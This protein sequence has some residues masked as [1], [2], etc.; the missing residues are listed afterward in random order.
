MYS[1][2]SILS[3]VERIGFGQDR[4]INIDDSN[5]IGKSGRLFSFYHKLVT[6]KNLY[7]TVEEAN[8]K[9]NDFNSYLTQLKIDSVKAIL[10]DI[11]NKNML[12]QNAFDYSDTIIN[13]PELFDDAIGYSVAISSI[14]QMITSPRINATVRRAEGAY[15]ALKIELEGL[16]VD[17]IVRSV[18]IKSDLK[19]SIQKVTE[20]LF[21]DP[22][23]V[24]SKSVW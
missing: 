16:K 7:E 11:F 19:E 17:G 10:T 22:L 23:I 1:E 4:L 15:Q 8:M 9:E 12:Y 24:D 21:P 14:Q 2:S 18:G 13:R 6:V 20:I 5:K 3:L